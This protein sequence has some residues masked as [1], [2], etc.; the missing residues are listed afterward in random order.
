VKF[1]LTSTT[2]RRA[3]IRPVEAEITGSGA[4]LRLKSGRREKRE[5]FFHKYH[6][7]FDAARKY[8]IGLNSIALIKLRRELADLERVEKRLQTL[9]EKHCVEIPEVTLSPE[10]AE[11]MV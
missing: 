4:F 1:Y 5:T 3:V 2:G 9:E 11:A 8:L 6:D 7:S 10:Q